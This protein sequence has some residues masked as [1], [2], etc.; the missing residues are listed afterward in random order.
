VHE[1]AVAQRMVQIALDAATQ[2]G[3]GRVA[4]ARLLLGALT[5]VEPETLTF[6]FDIAARDTCAE[7]CRLEIVRVPAR[8]RCRACSA[9]H[10]GELL[11]PCPVCHTPGSE[12]LEGR[13]LRLDSI[14]LETETAQPPG[15][16]A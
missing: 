1:V 6:A 2:N 8:L 14:D 16:S 13:E 7:G 4:G 3:G 5:C 12:V 11:D 10:G 15:G 9:E